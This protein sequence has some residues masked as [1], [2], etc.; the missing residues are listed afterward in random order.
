MAI[1]RKLRFDVFKRD[2]FSCQYCGNKPPRVVLEADHVIP[3]SRGGPDVMLNL[4]TSCFDCNRGKRDHSLDE[5][6]NPISD[7][8][9]QEKERAAQIKELTKFLTKKRNLEAKQITGLG[10]YWFNSFKVDKDKYCFGK[11]RVPSINQFLS[12]LNPNEILDAMDIAFRR[13][14]PSGDNDRKT[15]LYFCGICWRK[16]K[17][18][19][20]Y[21]K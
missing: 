4:V 3:K 1:S 5:I 10:A 20:K 9:A 12:H 21:A 16:I 7:Q 13:H 18:D 11:A 15:W 19:Y 8:L 17:K 14:P 6:P 2:F